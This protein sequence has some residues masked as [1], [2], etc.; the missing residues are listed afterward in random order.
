MTK[1]KVSQWT[2]KSKSQWKI[3]ASDYEIMFQHRKT[4][5]ERGESYR[6]KGLPGRTARKESNEINRD[7]GTET[8][9]FITKLLYLSLLQSTVRWYSKSCGRLVLGCNPCSKHNLRGKAGMGCPFYVFK[10]E[11]LKNLRRFS[12]LARV[13]TFIHASSSLPLINFRFHFLP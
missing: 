12:R 5:P 13:S 8:H 10:N 1:K 9:A 3:I 11:F 4:W 2:K 7:C 6:Q